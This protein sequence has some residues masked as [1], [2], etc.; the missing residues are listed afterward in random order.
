MVYNY[1]KVDQ[2]LL[3]PQIEDQLM[4]YIQQEQ[5]AVGSRLPSEH[6]LSERFGVGRS[7]VREAIKSLVTRGILEVKRGSGTFVKNPELDNGDPLGLSKYEDKYRLAMDLFDVRILLEPE[8]A[9]AACKNATKE[10]KDRIKELCDEIEMLYIDGKNHIKLDGEVKPGD[11]IFIRYE[12]PG[13]SGMPEMFYTG[14]AICADPKLASSVALITDGRFSAASR[15]PVIGH[16]SPEAAMGGPIAFVEKGDLI[17]I[18]IEARK[19]AVIGINGEK[20]TPEEIDDILAKRKANWK[21]FTSKYK[22]GLLKLYA[23]HAQS[24]MKGAYME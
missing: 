16:V 4:I 1:E 20:S 21:G 10:Q 2:K 6:K 18:D 19:I 7:T 23:Q 14:E 22:K 12:G 11:A 24:P 3:V 8:V 9:A 15:G 5:I 13:G 17:E